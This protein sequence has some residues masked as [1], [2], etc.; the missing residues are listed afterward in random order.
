MQVDVHL[1]LSPQEAA[2]NTSIKQA[3]AKKAN[4]SQ[5]DIA[6]LRVIRRSI[7]ARRKQV[8]VDL[9]VRVSTE[10]RD[11]AFAST[12]YRHVS[13][14]PSVVVVGAGPAGLFA[15]LRLLE[16]GL[17]PIVLERGTD[18]HQRKR[19][20]AQLVRTLEVNPESN[21]S[22]GEG[23]AGAFSDGKLYTR[24]TKRGDISKVLNQLCQH[25]ASTDILCDAHPHIGS[26]K[27]PLVIESIRNTILGCGG[28]VYFKTKVTTLIR[29]G[30]VVEGVQTDD[31]RSFLGPVILATGHSARD[32][33]R[34]IYTLG[35]EIESKGLAIGV[36]LEHQQQVIDRMQYKQ[37]EGRGPH[38]PAA[39]YSFV[40]Q[41][42]G[43]GVYSFCMCPGGFV[44]PA[45]T[46]D[47]QQVVNGM[48]ASGRSGRFANSG[49][50]VEIRPE[51]LSGERYSGPLGMLAFQEDVERRCFEAGG[52]SIKAPAQRMVD[53]LRHLR[54]GTL[55][56]TSYL[57]GLVDSDL[58]S[59]LPDFI[60]R[61]LAL[62]F[63][64]FG[65]KAPPFLTN[66]AL[67]LAAETRT[68]SPVRIPRDDRTRMHHQAEGLF[69]CGEGAGYAGGIV[70][71][72]MDCIAAAD[73]VKE[74]LAC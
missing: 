62:G 29:K 1:R 74:Y 42:E 53:F 73:H 46:A 11:T 32:V 21:Y 50:V 49:M 37:S 48:S 28:E 27:L 20:L 23:G 41:I 54:S 64:A 39:E 26:N 61:R 2:S 65:R 9:L 68:S 52:Y 59:V 12:S 45:A 57:P 17:K 38:L 22:F 44:I 58:H 7:E 35:L 19:D 16:L 34:M 40:E 6:S 70:S 72:A 30:T 36:R 69:P 56:E 63:E 71:A 43:R 47:G 15:A 55:C 10:T 60:A 4:L 33:Y 5:R 18:V 67:L 13:D 14:S 66:D 31:G 8:V 25:G 51:D 3:A 24:S